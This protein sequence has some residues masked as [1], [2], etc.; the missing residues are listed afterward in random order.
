MLESNNQMGAGGI[1]MQGDGPGTAAATIKELQGFNVE[2]LA[3]ALADTA[4]DVAAIRSE[5][6]ILKCLNNATG[7][8]LTDV[9]STM[10]INT[11]YATGTL[12]LSTAIAGSTAE[13]NGVTYTFQAGVPTA[14]GQV[15]VG[16]DDTE[17][18]VNLAT[19]INAYETSIAHGA[20]TVSATSAIAVVTVTASMEGVAA[21]AYTLVGGDGTVVAS[22]AT[23][24]GGTATGSVQ[25]TGATDQLIMFWYNKK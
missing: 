12:T 11:L 18:A 2:L 19:A 7:G 16:A 4:I 10:S 20:A 13:V 6:T 23:L 25:S 21:N 17:S 3:G 5:D 15:Q 24:T 22:A 8:V 1:G 14:Y 9:T